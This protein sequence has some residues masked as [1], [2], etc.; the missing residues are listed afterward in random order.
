MDKFDLS[1]SIKIKI[2][3]SI[4]WVLIS[5]LCSL[6]LTESSYSNLSYAKFAVSV[7][8]LNFPVIIYWLIFWTWGE[9]KVKSC[10][11]IAAKTTYEI[12]IFILSI[13]VNEIYYLL[14]TISYIKQ[15]ATEHWRGEQFLGKSFWINGLISWILIVPGIKISQT[16]PSNIHIFI[17]I[18]II[19]IFILVWYS[20]GLYR[21]ASTSAHNLIKPRLYYNLRLYAKFIAVLILLYC[22]I[23]NGLE[24]I[25]FYKPL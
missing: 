4:I 22:V 19:H 10:T 1:K 7:I 24:I 14:K 9:G 18:S 20:V 21:S 6:M 2:S 11:I 3:I 5:F 16:Y 23:Y 17:V 12:L 8:L 25:S 13:I 15:Y